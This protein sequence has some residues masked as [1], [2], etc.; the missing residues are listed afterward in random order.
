MR[1][2][3]CFTAEHDPDIMSQEVSKSLGRE[4]S[5]VL[6]TFFDRDEVKKVFHAIGSG[7]ETK[8]AD[9]FYESH[10][11]VLTVDVELD[12]SLE[13]FERLT[14]LWDNVPYSKA[15]FINCFLD[16]M[17]LGFIDFSDNE[18]EAMICSELVARV[19]HKWSKYKFKEDMDSVDPREVETVL[20]EGSTY[21]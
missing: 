17:G 11:N 2:E 5:H 21:A 10:Y 9:E 4:Y 20:M 1:I 7:V 3:V 8:L 14:L 15:Q 12:C 13:D 19:L 18:E 6:I 16:G